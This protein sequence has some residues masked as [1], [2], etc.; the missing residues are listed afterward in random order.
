M[1]AWRAFLEAHAYVTRL[2]EADLEAEKTLPLTWY[3]VLVQ[4]EEAEG[5][6]LRMTELADRVLLSKSGLTRLVDRMCDSGLVSRAPDD[7]DKRGRWVTM[8]PAGLARLHD[9]APVHM[10][11]IREYFSSQLSDDQAAAIAAALRRI[12]DTARKRGA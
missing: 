11:G 2:L 3:D 7:R 8:E 4:L 5:H 9:A 12:A 10:R 6:R 1:E